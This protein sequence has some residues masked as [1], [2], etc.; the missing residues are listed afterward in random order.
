M[1]TGSVTINH[2]DILLFIHR[3]SQKSYCYFQ[4]PFQ[5]KVVPSDSACPMTLACV[6]KHWRKDSVAFLSLQFNHYS[7][8]MENTVNILTQPAAS[9]GKHKKMQVCSFS[10]LCW[11]TTS[12]GSQVLAHRKYCDLWQGMWNKK[13][14]W[15]IHE[16]NFFRKMYCRKKGTH[17][18]WQMD[19]QVSSLQDKRRKCIMQSEAKRK[20]LCI[21]AIKTA[22]H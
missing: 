19:L 1:P 11:A 14:L 5:K 8:K 18:G 7:A 21:A 12:S 3:K 9:N 16:N 15:T 2:E 17:L 22:P 4:F 20:F 6:I 13:L 10:E